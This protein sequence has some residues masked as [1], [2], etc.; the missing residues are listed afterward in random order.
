MTDEDIDELISPTVDEIKSIIQ[1]DPA[2][3][4]LYLQG[5]GVND[6]PPSLLADT[7]A[8]AIMI[9]GSVQN[10][11]YVY[12]KVH[13]LIKKRIDEAKIG[14]L[15]VEGNYSI[16]S[17]DPYLLCQG[18][19][20]L[21]LTGI[22]KAGEIYNKYWLDKNVDKVACFRAPMTCHNSV[23]IREI[24]RSEEAQR[25]YRYMTTIT[26]LNSWDPSCQALNG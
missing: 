13:K 25:W 5:E 18:M 21:E 2:I 14:V 10:D 15:N 4:T 8:K 17:G 24:S 9:D 7:Y 3:A 16:L 22:L 1:T 23:L 20:G 6:H 26:I 11:V 12:Q 19:F